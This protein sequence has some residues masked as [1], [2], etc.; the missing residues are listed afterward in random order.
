MGSGRKG[1][2]LNYLPD[3]V[4]WVI[5][6][7]QNMTAQFPL[8]FHEPENERLEQINFSQVWK[9]A[10]GGNDLYFGFSELSLGTGIFSESKI[11]RLSVEPFIEPISPNSNDLFRNDKSQRD[12]GEIIRKLKN[13]QSKGYCLILS[14][15]AESEKDRIIDILKSEYQDITLPHR[16]VTSSLR[17]GFIYHAK[18]KNSDKHFENITKKGNRCGIILVTAREFLGRERSRKPQLSNKARVQRKEVDQSLDFTEL[19]NGDYLVHHQHGICR[20]CQLGKVGQGDE[21]EEAISVEFA[22]GL[23]LHVPLQ[24]SH[25]LS[26]YIGLQKTKPKLAKLG[27]KS[28]TRVKQAAEIAALD[29]AANLLRNQAFRNSER[30]HAFAPDDRWQ[31]KF[32]D[33]F[34]HT[35]TEDQILAIN[36]VKLDMECGKPMDRLVCGDVG[37]GKTEVAMR[38]AFKA[39]M[40]GKQVAVL[41]PT[42]I[43]C[44]QHFNSFRE[45]M[46]EFPVM[47]EM[48]SRFRTQGEQNKIIKGITSG[49]LIF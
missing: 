30:G 35:E 9:R 28:W 34:P 4:Q 46:K 7:P 10:H 47:I 23:L 25:L 38:A 1:E 39:V 15:G 33:L 17:N 18:A 45:R 2:F 6:E 20:F 22:D 36:A 5:N 40:G 21:L 19:I 49:E 24:E 16:V 41:A 12:R 44:Q 13:F 32:E 42:T 27:G 29:L 37:F 48:L 14:V 11:C 3:G 43:L 31:K 26:R 8:L